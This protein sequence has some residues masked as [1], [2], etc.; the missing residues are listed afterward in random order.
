MSYSPLPLLACLAIASAAPAQ[1]LIAVDGTT[2]MVVTFDPFTGSVLNP[3]LFAVPNTTQVAAIDVNGEIWITEQTG[4][5][6]TRRDLAGNVIATIGPTFAGGGFDNIRGLALVNGVVYVTNAGASNGA[7]ANSIVMLDTA[8]NHLQ[9]FTVNTLATSPF[10]VLAHQGDILVTGFSN[11]RDVYRFT[12]AGA[13]VGIFHDSTTISPAHGIAR[14]A[15][16]NVWVIGFTTA[17]VSKLDANT[18]AILTTFNAPSGSTPR[19]V[20]ELGN[21]NV[22]WSSGTAM[23]LLDVTTMTSTVVMNGTFNHISLYGAVVGGASATPFGTGCDGLTTTTNGLPQLGSAT[24][25]VLVNNVPAVSPI[26]FVAFASTAVNPGVSLAGVGMPGCFA[27]TTLDIG[28]FGA[29]PVVGGTSTF[30][31]PIPNDP[32]LQGFAL[33][34]QGVS[35]SSNTALGLATGN[36]VALVLGN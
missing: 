13:P 33:A 29:S 32:L 36:G 31:L 4:D 23:N 28:L 35:F 12:L 6:I 2:D 5:R 20:F 14:A 16:G 17:N 7:T 19:G 15:D 9:T 1:F 10:G 11:N 21:G 18:G 25:A 34:A 22:L 3:A 27:Y 8:G 26:G 30:A 24:F